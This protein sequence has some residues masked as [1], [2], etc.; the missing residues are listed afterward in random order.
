VHRTVSGEKY[1]YFFSCL[2]LH[3]TKLS[4]HLEITTFSSMKEQICWVSALCHS[5][6]L[7]STVPLKGKLTGSTR[8]SKFSES[9][10]LNRDFE[11]TFSVLENRTMAM[12]KSSIR[13]DQVR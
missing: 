11:E 2:S 1:F 8:N 4:E 13:L 3:H 9:S 6:I 5:I 7:I 12:L 10:F